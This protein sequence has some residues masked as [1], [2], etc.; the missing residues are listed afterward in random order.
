VSG[1]C[2]LPVD[3]YGAQGEA[4][5]GPGLEGTGRG[6]QLVGARTGF[7]QSVTAIM[8]PGKGLDLVGPSSERAVAWTG[9]LINSSSVNGLRCRR[10]PDVQK[11]GGASC[12]DA[13]T[14]ACG[15]TSPSQR[16]PS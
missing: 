16:Q 7:R 6:G 5:E 8:V 12:I 10:V 11:M 13:G 14:P 9:H 3:G 1:V 4:S 15:R 2:V